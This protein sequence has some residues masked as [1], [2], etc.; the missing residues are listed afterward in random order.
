[1]EDDSISHTTGDSDV[2]YA[3]STL[4]FPQKL[5]ILMEKEAGDVIQWASHGLCIRIVDEDTFVDVL[6]PKYFKQTKLTSFQRQLNLYGFRRL[7]KGEDQGCYFHPKFQRR[8]RDLLSEIKRMPI[9]GSLPTYDQLR[10]YS[11]KLPTERYRSARRGGTGESTAEV[12]V[13]QGVMPPPVQRVETRASVRQMHAVAPGRRED[14]QAPIAPAT[15]HSYPPHIPQ[16]QSQSLAGNTYP[17]Y[18]AASSAA[19]VRMSKLTQNFGFGRNNGTLQPGG[20]QYPYAA[21]SYSYANLP[22]HI[23]ISSNFASES[24]PFPVPSL[25]SLPSS[26]SLPSI[27]EDYDFLDLLKGDVGTFTPPSMRS[28]QVEDYTISFDEAFPSNPSS[29]QMPCA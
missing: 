6:M 28:S 16:G 15:T 22:K 10:S 3:N 11:N 20:T 27:S 5:F 23:P 9:K 7:T 12:N 29:Q 4:T 18:P 17:A 26:S 21:P 14:V 2:D 8:R 24:R 1:M 25:P 13:Q 19:P